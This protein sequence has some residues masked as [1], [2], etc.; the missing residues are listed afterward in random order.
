MHL[1]ISSTVPF[2]LQ[3]DERN[4]WGQLHVSTKNERKKEERMCCIQKNIFGT[5]VFAQENETYQ[6]I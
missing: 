1:Q 6:Q 2:V 5:I 3:P 4:R